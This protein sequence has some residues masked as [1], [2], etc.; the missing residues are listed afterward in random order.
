VRAFPVSGFENQQRN[1]AGW[2]TPAAIRQRP[3]NAEWEKTE[4]RWGEGRVAN[5]R[6]D[7]PCKVPGPTTRKIAEEKMALARFT[8]SL[9]G[10]GRILPACDGISPNS[11]PRERFG[12][13]LLTADSLLLQTA[14]S[15]SVPFGHR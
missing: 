6:G 9:P 11:D 13:L 2:G 8:A 4:Q 14:C 7:V 15:G 3:D 1:R 12:N 5:R 10:P